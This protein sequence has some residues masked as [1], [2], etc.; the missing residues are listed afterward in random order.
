MVIIDIDNKRVVG[1]FLGSWPLSDELIGDIRAC[2]PE[3][4]NDPDARRAMAEAADRLLA[5]RAAD[6]ARRSAAATSE[7]GA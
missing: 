4:A 5:R 2:V 3:I 1:S 7:P 6:R